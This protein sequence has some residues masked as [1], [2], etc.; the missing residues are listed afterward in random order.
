M[1]DYIMSFSTK[2]VCGGTGWRVAASISTFYGPYF[3]LTSNGSTFANTD[4]SFV[5][6]NTIAV[7]YGYT[8]VN[9]TILH[10]SDTIPYPC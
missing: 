1:S 8:I 3:I 7:G 4:E 6:R 9:Q 2:I 10:R 5:P